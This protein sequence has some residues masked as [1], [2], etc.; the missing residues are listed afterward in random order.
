LV[1]A[2]ETTNSADPQSVSITADVTGTP[3]PAVQWQKSTGGAFVNLSNGGNISG[4]T[5]TNLTISPTSFADSASYRI[6]ATNTAGSINS[7]VVAVQI[8][9]TIPDVTQPG[10]PITDSG[11]QR[12][13]FTS[14][15]D[16]AIDDTTTKYENPGSG[17]N[18]NA[19]FPPFAGPVSLTVTPAVGSTIVTGLRIYTADANPERD[20]SNYALEGSNDGTNFVPI[21]SGQISLPL[22]RNAAALP[23]DPITQ[24]M[25]EVLFPN[26]PSY[27]SY[28][29][30]F[31]HVRDD[32][33]ASELQFAEMELLGV[34][35]TSV[36]PNPPML[37]FSAGQGSLT[38]TSSANGTLQSTTA[39]DG[40]NTVWATDQPIT[41]GTPLNI[42][43]DTS[44]PAKFYRVKTP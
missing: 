18:V 36:V 15:P 25:Q 27:K 35:G 41:A 3:A 10:D 33:N 30:T 31:T 34:P 8:I 22:D 6:T 21:T 26:N 19:G 16:N 20:P 28:R 11:N 14:L 23:V 2:Y 32:S 40:T 5:T 42:P 13:G 17:L 43:I 29:I 4:A 39:L 7:S 1:K 12:A 44:V 9:S 38:V 37:T 24:A